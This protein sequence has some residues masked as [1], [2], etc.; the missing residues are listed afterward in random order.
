MERFKRAPDRRTAT[1]FCALYGI[2]VPPRPAALA[3]QPR[4]P[5]PHYPSPPITSTL[6]YRGYSKTYRGCSSYIHTCYMHVQPEQRSRLPQPQPLQ[7]Q[8]HLVEPHVSIIE[9]RRETL[10]GLHLASSVEVGLRPGPHRPRRRSRGGDRRVAPWCVAAPPACGGTLV[11]LA[12]AAAAPPAPRL[13]RGQPSAK[14]AQAAPPLT[15][16]RSARRRAFRAMA[17]RRLLAPPRGW[18]RL[19]RRDVGR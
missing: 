18:R 17:M 1:R 5:A 16:R 3:R 15:R 6:Q 7:L 12:V 8:L 11:D 9:A 10:V 14:A 2:Y 4:A 13:G 19:R